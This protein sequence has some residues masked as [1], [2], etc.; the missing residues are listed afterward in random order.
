[1]SATVDLSL[2]PSPDVVETLS[3]ET[4]MADMLADLRSRHPQF[5]A[6]NESDPAYKILEVCAYRETLLRARVNDSCRAVMLA[7][8]TGS[9]L[10]QIAANFFGTAR[11]VITP[12]DPTTIPPTAAVYETDAAFRSRVL[13]AID[14]M[15]VAGPAAAY[16]FH[17]KSASGSVKD[18]SC[19]SPTP[20]AVLISVLGT[21]GDGTPDAP[22]LAAVRAALTNEDVR[23]LTDNVTVQAA[24]IVPYTIAASIYTKPG[25]DAAVVMAAARAAAAALAGT[26]HALGCDITIS[27]LYAALHQAGVQR[28]VLTSPAADIAI[29]D[30]QAP[31][32]TAIILTHA[33]TAQ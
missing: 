21:A 30:T 23:P 8:A 10:D 6:L 29:S 18:A 7:S 28:V 15:S 26:S 1:M 11:L 17:A 4:I 9:D 27:A 19:V 33:G 32:C 22:T 12:A 24:E 5:T 3:F 20:G 16:V 31:H 2:L 25:P 13:L 14:S